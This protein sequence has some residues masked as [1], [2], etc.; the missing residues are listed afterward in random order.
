MFE[1]KRLPKYKYGIIMGILSILTALLLTGVPIGSSTIEL[2][3]I[4]IF[5][6]GLLVML[7]ISLKLK[8]DKVSLIYTLSYLVIVFILTSI[9]ESKYNDFQLYAIGWLPGFVISIIGLIRSKA[10]EK[11]YDNKIGMVLNI[12]GLVLSII[13]LILIIPNGGFIIK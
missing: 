13:S 1:H 9:I 8:K 11:T 3:N 5:L 2:I 7:I 12:I 10:I 6:L 4:A